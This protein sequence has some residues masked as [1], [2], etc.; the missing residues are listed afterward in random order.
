VRSNQ[1]NYG[2]LIPL[3]SEGRGPGTLARAARAAIAMFTGAAYYI[4]ADSGVAGPAIEAVY[5]FW[6]WQTTVNS[7]MVDQGADFVLFKNGEVWRNPGAGPR[8]IDPV[9]F[10]EAR[11]QDWGSW[12]T[13]LGRI[14]I[15]LNGQA[16]TMLPADKF[17]RYA[18][19]TAQRVE[20]RWK[21]NSS[22][23]SPA[24]FGGSE[25]LISLHANGRFEEHGFTSFTST[26]GGRSGS[27][28]TVGAGAP[29]SSGQYRIDGYTLDVTYDD[30][31]KSS[32]LFY[33]APGSDSP[34]EMCVINGTKYMGGLLR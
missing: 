9:R 8:D 21:W 6:N 34:Y 20:G 14:V 22:Y 4:S 11:W 10:K 30:G 23:S 2:A 31:H 26:S 27:A 32:A 3:A 5:H 33:W 28:A 18:P 29:A 15:T 12:R 13:Q 17:V 24:S 16:A 25:R 19:A 7:G 1:I